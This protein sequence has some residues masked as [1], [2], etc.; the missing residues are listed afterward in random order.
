MSNADPLIVEDY[1]DAFEEVS[2]HLLEFIVN[3]KDGAVRWVNN[4]VYSLVLE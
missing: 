4:R 1:I 3:L 2:T